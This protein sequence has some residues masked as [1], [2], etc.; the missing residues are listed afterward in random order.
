[1]GNADLTASLPARQAETGRHPGDPSTPCECL[2][3]ALAVEVAPFGIKVLI[4]EPGAFRTGLHRTGTRQE[5]AA[6]PAD[7][8]IIGPVRAQQAAFDGKQPGDPAKAAAAIITALS[9]DT[10]PLRLPLGNDAAD[11]IAASLDTTCAELAA[12]DEVTGHRPR[13]VTQHLAL[14]E[15]GAP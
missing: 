2:S 10:T 5:T 3:E 4:V 6:I 7:N 9:A 1:L 13:P 11:A 8:D 15:T 12:W 14:T